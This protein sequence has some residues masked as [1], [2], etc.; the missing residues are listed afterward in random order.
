[1]SEKKQAKFI[2][3][4]N[5]LKDRIKRTEGDGVDFTAAEAAMQKLAPEFIA[6][7]PKDLEKIQKAYAT[8]TS[9]PDN[10]DLRTELF[11]LVHDLPDD[12]QVTNIPV[13]VAA[14]LINAGLTKQP[15]IGFRRQCQSI[16]IGS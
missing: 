6:R 3:P 2:R 1:M 12:I 13:R 4:P 8:L 14:V 15:L 9:N 16:N 10:A 5:L 11:R 7:L